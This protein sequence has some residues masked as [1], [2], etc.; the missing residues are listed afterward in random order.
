M[1]MK[2]Y[3]NPNSGLWKIFCAIFYLAITGVAIYAFIRGEIVPAIILLVLFY[4]PILILGI[5]LLKAKKKKGAEKATATAATKISTSSNKSNESKA[6][7]SLSF[8]STEGTI[9]R[10]KE[11]FEKADSLLKSEYNDEMFG[12]DLEGNKRPLV[13]KDNEL[14]QE[15]LCDDIDV[16]SAAIITINNLITTPCKLLKKSI[17]EEILQG[18][19]E[20]TPYSTFLFLN[21]YYFQKYNLIL[22][23][24]KN[25]RTYFAKLEEYKFSLKEVADEH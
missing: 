23:V 2:I 15:L 1:K 13:Y 17:Q 5:V 25:Q 3:Y 9:K 11:V 4:T 20:V 6:V 16:V 7:P 24:Y 14:I 8:D 19:G 10:C 21:H 22:V 12:V 18:Y